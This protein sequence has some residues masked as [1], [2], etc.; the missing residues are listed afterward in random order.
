LFNISYVKEVIAT[1]LFLLGKDRKRLPLLWISVLIA[2]ALDV[3]GVGLVLPFLKVATQP[4]AIQ[5]IAWLKPIAT[6]AWS[7]GQ[8]VMLLGI[9]FLVIFL[10]KSYAAASL[11]LY[12]A[13]FA[14]QQDTAKRVQLLSSFMFAP[15]E[16]HLDK[17]R[18]SIINS[19]VQNINKFSSSLLALLRML[20]ELVV[21][22]FLIILLF[23]AS[24]LV[25][26]VL[27]LSLLVISLLYMYLT[28][29]GALKWGELAVTSSQGMLKSIQESIEGLKEIRSLGVENSFINRLAS[30]GKISEQS[31]LG[32]T[33]LSILPRYVLECGFVSVVILLVI[34]SVN[35][36][37][38]MFQLVP[39]LAL[40][41]MAGLRLLPSIYTIVTSFSLV[42]F[43]FPAVK[44]VRDDMEN[45]KPPRAELGS[46]TISNEQFD[47][48]SLRNV[49]FSYAQSSR[50]I[51]ADISIDVN[52]QQSIGI[53]G[54]SGAGKTTLIDLMLC[55]LA[56]TKGEILVNGRSI[57]S[58]PQHWW[59]MVAYIP[60]TPFL[61]D[62]TIRRNIALGLNESCID[63]RRIDN[64]I[65]TAQLESFINQ[66]PN[67]K[68]TVIGDRGIRL[69][70][71]QR[72]RI[73]IARAI[74][75]DR[76]VFIFD[77]ATSALDAKTESEIV[78]AIEV[79]H[80]SKTMIIIAHRM[81]TLAHCDRILEISNGRIVEVPALVAP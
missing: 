81:S 38:N 51:I 64:A 50:E 37:D 23:V 57:K 62:D 69:S 76:Q 5:E 32:L 73:A 40:L 8:I 66:L 71:G 16:Y 52:R 15:Y 48:L 17:D 21:F 70:G 78:N 9:S 54:G 6:L 13:R 2:S 28:R 3:A 65:A 29:G 20:S 11:Q 49:S 56:P 18:A 35:F 67:G 39:M 58:N 19:M 74:Y 59:S 30:F 53:I 44:Q 7:H 45:T 42:R 79:L 75:Y 46:T 31:S 26:Y 41:G 1:Y 61:S 47:I 12:I 55:L 24:P 77:E 34:F 14:Y 68:D 25:F 4:E 80:H 10:V 36:E 27:S 22:V 72:Q 33:R 43:S 60:Q 63:E